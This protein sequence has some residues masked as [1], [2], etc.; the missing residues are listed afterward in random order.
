VIP[1]DAVKRTAS[2]LLLLTGFA[3]AAGQTPPQQ[4]ETRLRAALFTRTAADGTEFGASELDILYFGTTHHLIDEPSHSAALRA[5]DE[6]A[7]LDA[8][9][10]PADPV[11]RALLQ[12]DLWQLFDWARGEFVTIDDTAA[13]RTALRE[14]I[15][16]AMKRLL[17]SDAQIAKLP[18]N[19]G[20]LQNAPALVGIAQSLRSANG[21]WVMLGT[22]GAEPAAPIHT[23]E[24][25]GRS[26]FLVM[27]H[28]PKGR[29]AA[30][31][32]LATLPLGAPAE[33]TPALNFAADQ[34]PPG[35]TWALV[36][37]MNVIDQRGH[38]RPTHLVESAQLRTY[39]DE[40][41][42]DQPGFGAAGVGFQRL[43]EWQLDRWD[44]P[45]LRALAEWD[46][47]F[48][49]GMGYDWFEAS[50]HTA[51]LTSGLEPPF[52]FCQACHQLMGIRG[53]RSLVGFQGRATPAFLE[54][55]FG[56]EAA[57]VA[58]IK[59]QRPDWQELSGLLREK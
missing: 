16:A 55:T 36:R 51:A 7:A 28:L 59:E 54:T 23:A 10:L 22:S 34:F 33:S 19:L 24:K 32:W 39:T 43:G 56:P 50:E 37:V 2:L 29:M 4:A 27:V 18:D 17:L 53:I 57:K 15:A 30:R 41:P 48:S 6:F 44:P 8:S 40:P 11:R 5:L 20:D 45:R 49:R 1:G 21:D 46:R 3:L 26:V 14:R 12:R 35:T 52:K 13:R 42:G 31:D 38:I 25:Q 58:A 47:V 9:Q